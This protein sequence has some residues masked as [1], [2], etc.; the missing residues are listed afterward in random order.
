MRLPLVTVDYT[1]RCAIN[2]RCR[3]QHS[4][5]LPKQIL[6]NVRLSILMRLKRNQPPKGLV[7]K[8]IYNWRSPPIGGITL[9]TKGKLTLDKLR[10][11]RGRYLWKSFERSTRERYYNEISQ[12]TKKADDVVR[13]KRIVI[14]ENAIYYKI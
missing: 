6:I 10:N 2:L 5:H 14:D 8:N 13:W 12:N 3:Y 11:C 4:P 9:Q 7:E 1:N